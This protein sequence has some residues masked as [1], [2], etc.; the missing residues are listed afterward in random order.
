MN[1]PA[2]STCPR[3]RGRA[4]LIPFKCFPYAV[5]FEKPDTLAPDRRRRVSKQTLGKKLGGLIEKPGKRIQ[6][7]SP[8]CGQAICRRQQRG[9]AKEKQTRESTM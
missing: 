4:G 7:L 6:I 3:S 2:A 5:V 9:T 8:L 1:D